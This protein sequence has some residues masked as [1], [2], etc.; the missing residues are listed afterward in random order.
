MTKTNFILQNFDTQIFGF[1]VYNYRPNSLSEIENAAA[2][3]P[4][5]A[6]LV[7]MR[8]PK[9]WSHLM[10]KTQFRKIECLVVMESKLENNTSNNL[11]VNVRICSQ[12]DA[13]V[14]KII[15]ANCFQHD[16][17]HKD[18]MIDDQTAAATKAQWAFNNVTERG[19]ASFVI[20]IENEI[21]GFNLCLRSTTTAIIDLIGVSPT[22]QGKGFGRKLVKAA[23][24]YYTNKAQ[25]IRVGTQSDNHASISLYKSLGFQEVEEYVTYHW[26]SNQNEDQ[27]CRKN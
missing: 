19:D 2:E 7:C 5:D 13:E 6:G 3:I 25:I 18:P 14:C 17:Y 12:A 23:L 9:S 8:T 21:L 24:N 1:P 10:P 22:H 26:T 4:A 11:P 27:R 20:E 16:R 15:A